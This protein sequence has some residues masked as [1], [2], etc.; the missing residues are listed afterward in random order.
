LYLVQ[1]AHSW[2]DRPLYLFDEWVAYTNG[3]EC[4]KELNISNWDYE[5]LQAHNFNVYCMYLAMLAKSDDKQFKSFMM[6]NIERTF[7][8]LGNQ[9]DVLSYIDKVRHSPEAEDLR[10]FARSYFGAAWCKKVYGF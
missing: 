10:V 6:W 4:G 8:L 2:N 9:N 3:S 7:S 5:L 1:Q